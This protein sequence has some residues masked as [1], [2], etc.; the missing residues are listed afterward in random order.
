MA[1]SFSDYGSDDF[2][3]KMKLKLSLLG[4]VLEYGFS[5]LYFDS[6]VIIFKDPFPVLRRYQDYDFVAQRDESI[7]AGYIYMRPAQRTI[8]LVNYARSLMSSM[9]VDDQD[10]LNT[11]TQRYYAHWTL[12]PSTSFPSGS[13]FFNRYQYYWDRNGG[14]GAAA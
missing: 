6:D 7:C 8:G 2:K 13:I 5:L 9:N 4:T 14:C 12:L 10:L 1:G 3:H 11:A